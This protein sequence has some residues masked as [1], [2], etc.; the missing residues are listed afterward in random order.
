MIAPMRMVMPESLLL[1]AETDGLDV[2]GVILWS[3]V[4]MALLIAGLVFA[5]RLKRRMNAEDAEPV[6]V[7]GFTLSDLRQM[8]RAG[9][10][11]V[12]EFAK[13]KEKVVAAAQKAA[14]RQQADPADP[15]ERDSADAIR[16]RRLA[17][18]AMERDQF[19]RLGDGE[20]ED[21]REDGRV[22]PPR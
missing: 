15:P 20:D 11:S 5:M 4:L 2:A 3:A 13:A 19:P 7:A 12:A 17:R 9:Q 21:G 18:E 6:P 14:E 1:L 16:A 10:I 8:H 22:R